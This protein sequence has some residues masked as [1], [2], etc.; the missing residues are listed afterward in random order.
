[1]NFKHFHEFRN[2]RWG[3][4]VRQL[5]FLLILVCQMYGFYFEKENE[6]NG[7]RCNQSGNEQDYSTNMMVDEDKEL[8]VIIAITCYYP[9]FHVLI[10]E[11][12]YR[13]LEKYRLSIRNYNI[14]MYQQS[15]YLHDKMFARNASK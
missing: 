9:S 6:N 2:Q 12:C 5:Q 4:I 15:F 14:T 10:S 11:R 8:F 1:M 13:S 7:K 3:L